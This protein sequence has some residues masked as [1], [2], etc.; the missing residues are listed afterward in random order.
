MK[1]ATQNILL[2]LVTLFCLAVTIEFLYY[3]FLTVA[4]L[5]KTDGALTGSIQYINCHYFILGGGGLISTV[6][7]VII[8]IK[9]N[10]KKDG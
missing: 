8:L 4:E 3:G 9:T 2:I 7:C 5:I 6:L 1:K 10:L